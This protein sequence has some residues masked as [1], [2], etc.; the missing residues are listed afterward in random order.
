MPVHASALLA[1]K[2]AVVVLTLVHA[3]GTLIDQVR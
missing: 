1:V 2:A 3:T